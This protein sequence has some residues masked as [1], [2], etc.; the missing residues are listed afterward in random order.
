MKA[1]AGPFNKEDFE[2]LVPS[3]KKLDPGWVKSLFARGEPTIYRNSEL[4][5]IGMPVGGIC[6][7]QLYLGGDGRLL[8][9]DIFNAPEPSQFNLYRGPNYAKPRKPTAPLEQGFALKIS[10]GG[11][12]EVR[13]LDKVGFPGVA[14]CGQY[15]IGTI[16][17]HDPACP[18]DVKM[19][20]YSPFIPLNP[21]DSGLPAT[22]M[23]F[24]ITNTSAESLEVELAGWLE[25]AVCKFSKP[26]CSV[27]RNRVARDGGMLRVESSIHP[28]LRVVDKNHPDRPD[29]VFA[30]FEDDN[31]GAWTVEG[32]AF[33][34]RPAKATDFHGNPPPKKLGAHGQAL[35]NSVLSAPSIGGSK[36]RTTGKLT[37]P[38]FTIERN[39]IRFLIGG[40]ED[41]KHL[42]LRLM[43]D[44]QMVRSATGHTAH[45]LRTDSFD[46]SAFIGRKARL[47]IFDESTGGWGNIGVDYI[48]FTDLAAPP[49]VLQGA[50]DYGTL[51][52]ALLAS[53]STDRACADVGEANAEAVFTALNAA[54]KPEAETAVPAKLIGALGRRW[55]LK[56]GEQRKAAFVI[57]WHFAQTTYTPLL[58][59]DTFSKIRDLENLRRYYSR[60]FRDS[61]EV[62]VYVAKDFARLSGETR[63]WRDTWYDST[64]PHWLLD[65]MLMN[66]SALATA[67]CNRF[68]SGRYWFFE[69][70]YCCQGNCTSVWFYTQGAGR[71]FPSIEQSIH[72]TQHFVDGIGFDPKTGGVWTRGEY[73]GD[74]VLDGQAGHV[75]TSYR[76][77]QMSND[78]T[79]LKN[80]WP[81]IKRILEWL[82][83]EDGNADG[84]IDGK[85]STTLDT[86]LWWGAMSWTSSLYLA[87]LRAGEEMARDMG[88]TEFA[89]TARAIAD[90][91]G[92]NLVERLWNGEY[93]IHKP[94]PKQPNSFIIGNGCHIDQVFGQGWANQVGLGRILPESHTQ[95]ALRSVWKYNFTPDVGPYRQLNKAGSWYAMP[96]EGGTIMTTWPHGDQVF[97]KVVSG[98][99]ET[100]MGYL[101]TCMAGYEHQVAGH[102]ISEGLVLEGLAA[103][104][105]IHDRYHA[106]RRNPWNEVECGDHY[107]RG[108]ASYGLLIA[109]SGFEYHGPKGHIGFAPRLT[110]E[111]FRAPFTSTAGWGTFW[112]KRDAGRTGC[113][114]LLRWGKLRVKTLALALAE[115][116]S[117]STATV[118]LGKK[119]IPASVTVTAHRALITFAEQIELTPEAEFRLTL[120]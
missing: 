106:S 119:A 108:M 77:H 51:S 6:T 70:T 1:M 59:N 2:K 43:I 44:G 79:F 9:W 95:S 49:E 64:L 73:R 112:Q 18:V 101:N 111:N 3:D 28:E 96:G 99:M 80:N 107:S 23:E 26:I 15:P 65:R 104:R 88:D 100:G 4:A 29:I 115:G 32:T 92:R 72:E 27:R 60:K 33:G 19:E 38:E 31:Y 57:S 89:A 120:S 16:N 113:G 62:A 87:A 41:A 83:Q 37:S 68:D 52:L 30:D 13:P 118:S 35:A 21:E 86:G 61:N 10:K 34:S 71:L 39:F 8:H 12:A 81:K 36:E 82:I 97:P 48:L 14:F 55:T 90:A 66:V 69:G 46:T 47:E 109:A 45:L 20:A 53:E 103:E 25:N 78:G 98:D 84:I 50:A 7:G 117:A 76:T 56:P 11:K 42:G 93:F 5:Y 110:P 94:D 75:L 116:A 105:M 114:I 54:N 102:M 67:T 17:Y 40:G 74:F 91:G 85:Q 58:L 63:R 24:S 22:V